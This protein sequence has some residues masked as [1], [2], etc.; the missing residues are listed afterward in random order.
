MLKCI[1][2]NHDVAAEALRVLD[3]G[4]TIGRDDHRHVGVE[5]AVNEW[6]ILAIS[7]EHYSRRRSGRAKPG[8]QIRSERRLPGATDG[9]VA[10]AQSG[11]RGGVRGEYA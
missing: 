8:G 11:N 4:Q 10:D 9:E 7:A 5:R 6:F 1:V 2:E 3:A